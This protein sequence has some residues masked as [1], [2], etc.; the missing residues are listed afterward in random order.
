MQGYIILCSAFI[1]IPVQEKEE[2]ITRLLRTRGLSMLAY[3]CG[4]FLFDFSYFLL[5]YIVLILW[6]PSTFEGLPFKLLASTGVSMILYTYSCSLI[7]EKRKTANNW[8]TIVNSLLLLVFMPFMIPN[9][10]FRDTLY[11]NIYFL[12]FLY[13][14]FDLGSHIIGN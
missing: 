8:F 10:P 12:R 13:P 3:W 7:F 6:L 11:G 5:N 1:S 2:K 14:Y 4:H 9:S